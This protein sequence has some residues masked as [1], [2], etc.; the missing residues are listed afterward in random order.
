M[1]VVTDMIY[2][3]VATIDNQIYHHTASN[4]RSSHRDLMKGPLKNC[5]IQ[6]S[7]QELF[8]SSV[9]WCR[10]KMEEASQVS[11]KYSL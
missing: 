3:L 1:A 8:Y 9:T 11:W 5:K 7:H 2:D 4:P 10:R 6:D